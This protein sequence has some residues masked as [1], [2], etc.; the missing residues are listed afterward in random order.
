MPLSGALMM[1]L[2]TWADFCV[3]ATSSSRSDDA[4]AVIDA[5]KPSVAKIRKRFNMCVSPP[6]IELRS[7]MICRPFLRTDIQAA[8]GEN[9]NTVIALERRGLRHEEAE[10]H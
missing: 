8:A 5:I 9:T 10:V 2:K 3:R 6:E 1:S 4:S 7:P